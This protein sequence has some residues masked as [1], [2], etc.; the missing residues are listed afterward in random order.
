M[1]CAC[2]LIVERSLAG[3]FADINVLCGDN[4]FYSN[5]MTN[6]IFSNQTS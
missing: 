6:R 1:Q 3:K 2:Q 5:L 4:Y